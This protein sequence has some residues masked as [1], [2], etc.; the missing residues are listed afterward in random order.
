MSPVLD[1]FGLLV[2]LGLGNL[3]G[4]ELEQGVGEAL[5]DLVL[6][7]GLQQRLALLRHLPELVQLLHRHLEPG[8]LL[9]RR[10]DHFKHFR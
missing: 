2:P 8:T 3:C 9:I 1:L 7:G 4:E 6:P 10:F 5:D